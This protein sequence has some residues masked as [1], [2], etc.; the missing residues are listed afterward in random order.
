MKQSIQLEE[1]WVST[2]V[3]KVF[4]GSLNQLEEQQETNI[5]NTMVKYIIL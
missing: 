1:M 2:R 5:L 4:P 3:R